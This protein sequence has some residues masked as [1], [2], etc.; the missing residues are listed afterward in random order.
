M[1]PLFEIQE[2][3]VY[4][5]VDSA[6]KYDDN[7]SV[8]FLKVDHF[9][10]CC[11]AKQNNP[12]V[13][14]VAK[15]EGGFSSCDELLKNDVLKYSIWILG[16]MAF[17]G[18]FFVIVWRSFSKDSNRVASFLLT[19]LAVADFLM[20]VYLLIISYKDTVWNGV[21]FKHDISWRASNLCIFAGVI[22]TLSSEVS[23]L[24]LTVITLE[25]MICII[26]TLKFQRWSMKKAW[27]IMIV[28]WL[29]GLC[30]SIIPLLNDAYFYDYKQ[31]AHFFGRS[32]VCLPLQ[33]SSDRPA[34]WEYSVCVFLV[35][36]GV[37]F[38]FILL[39]Y[40]FM[41]RSIVKAARSVRSTRVK[42]DSTIAKRMMFIILTDFL[43][44]FPVIILSILALTGN[45]YDPS[46]QVYAWVAV[47]V[48]PINSSINP[49]LYTFS[50]P[51][52]RKM[53]PSP[54]SWIAH[55]IF[56]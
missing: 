46:K 16:L 19:N 30:I 9:T 5:S 28:V 36:N 32:P 48:L 47:F 6:Y 1:S 38:L 37:S 34:G 29:I 10:L 51:Y 20:G 45:L 27:G 31:N 39:A 52:V 7:Y 33:L 3:N 12:S 15:F 24:T 40:V 54:L 14:C 41:Y 44:W 55:K 49:L 11:F 4:A 21:Y 17:L 18:N 26:F 25:R 8:N 56:N 50:T 53:I 35:L 2:T 42:K 22:S 23:V 43:C 13:S